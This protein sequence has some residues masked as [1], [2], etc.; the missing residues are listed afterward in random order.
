MSGS[1]PEQSAGHHKTRTT[2]TSLQPPVHRATP[3]GWRTRPQ[4]WRSRP[5]RTCPASAPRPCPS[6]RGPRRS[7]RR[8][9]VV[10][11]GWGE[12]GGGG[13]AA[14]A[15]AHAHIEASHGGVRSARVAE[16]IL[17]Q[18][19][20]A[21]RLIPVIEHVFPT[22]YAL[23]AVA[24]CGEPGGVLGKGAWRAERGSAQNAQQRRCGQNALGVC[25]KSW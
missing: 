19:E 16:K 21:Q 5:P 13:G 25:S 9:P 6:Q 14:R 11:C 12:R 8:P 7:S 4:S 10:L 1:D 24:L 22:F 18:Q 17:A 23:A 20:G 2:R 3:A 15:G